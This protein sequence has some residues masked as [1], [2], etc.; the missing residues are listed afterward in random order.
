MIGV[1]AG[2]MVRKG[3]LLEA[4]LEQ[5]E[6][7]HKDGCNVATS[8]HRDNPTSRRWVNNIKVNKRQRRE[9]ST[10]RRL[11]IAALQQRDVSADSVLSSFKSKKGCVIRTIGN[12]TN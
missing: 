2:A 11:N 3:Q 7:M 6:A 5:K 12:R 8:P 10:L 9:V 1:Y 4:I